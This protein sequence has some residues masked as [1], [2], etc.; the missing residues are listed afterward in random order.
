[1]TGVNIASNTFV[2]DECDLDLVTGTGS[3]IVVDAWGT[4]VAETLFRLERE[5]FFADFSK[6]KNLGIY[7]G[8]FEKI[9]GPIL[10]KE[11]NF[12]KIR[13]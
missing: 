9:G 5:G 13:L 7:Y 12:L 11:E 2:L 1:M 8:G 10:E 6:K 4:A 3:T